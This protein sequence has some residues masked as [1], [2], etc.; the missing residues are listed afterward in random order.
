MLLWLAAELSQATGDKRYLDRTDEMLRFIEQCQ[1]ASG[2]LPYALPT[3]THFMCYQYNSFQFL[4]LAHYYQIA[5]GERARRVLGKLAAFLSLGVTKRG[6]SRSSCSTETPE[7]HYWTA[8]LAAALRKAHEL[9]LG[10]YCAA[11]ERAYRYLLGRQRADGGYDFSERE[12][13]LLRDRR[14]YPRYLVM[15]LYLLLCRAG[16]EKHNPPPPGRASW[17]RPASLDA[18]HREN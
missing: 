1:L 4:D 15:I 7:V 18:V 10:D 6:R 9:E 13:G 14:S 12:Y 5:G 17:V 16:G 2:E 11:S 8:V 3:R